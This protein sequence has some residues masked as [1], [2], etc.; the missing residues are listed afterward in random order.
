[1][2]PLLDEGGQE[3]PIEMADA[4]SR[5]DWLKRTSDND[6]G[7]RWGSGVH[8]SP[9]MFLEGQF[10]N[11]VSVS[12]VEIDEGFWISDS[13]RH[14][15]LQLVDGDNRC[16]IY[17]GSTSPLHNFYGAKVQFKV[18]QSS[19]GTNYTQATGLRLEQQGKHPLFDW[20][21]AEINVFSK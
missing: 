12:R 14:L 16:L 15:S 7:S 19:V 20:S 18:P 11:R 1:M 13:A 21:V 4:S 9:G 3:I 10:K 8:Q 6:R 5:K 17:E 2:N